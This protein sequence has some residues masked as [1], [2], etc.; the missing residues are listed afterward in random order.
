MSN[1]IK[2]PRTDA[3]PCII[4]TSGDRQFYGVREEELY[5][6]ARTLE[7]ETVELRSLALQKELNI[8]QLSANLCEA[9][10]ELKTAV[11]LLEECDWNSHQNW[12]CCDGVQPCKCGLTEWNYK[13][14]TF[15]SAHKK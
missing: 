7:R 10:S 3:L 8:A 11:A 6:F 13:K 9:T 2:T 5:N 12:R 14:K 4:Q 1:E 15:L